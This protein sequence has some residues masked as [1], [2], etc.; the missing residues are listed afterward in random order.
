[1]FLHKLNIDTDTKNTLLKNKKGHLWHHEN[2]MSNVSAMMTAL[3]SEIV[4]PQPV[5]TLFHVCVSVPSD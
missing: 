1:M 5:K 2:G 3:L 4:N